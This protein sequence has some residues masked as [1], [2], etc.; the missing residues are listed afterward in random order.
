[1]MNLTT[2]ATLASLGLPEP[3]AKYADTMDPIWDLI[4]W[5]TTFFF[6]IIVGTLILFMIKYHRRKGRVLE[7]APTHHT[8]L[9]IAWTIIPLIIVIALFFIGAQGFNESNAIPSNAYHIAVHGVQWHFDFIYPNGGT[10]NELWV[11]KDQ[12]VV[13]DMT[14]DNVS[15]GLYIPDF[16]A[17]RNIVPGRMVQM[18]FQATEIGDHNIFCTQ[19]CGNGPLRHDHHGPCCRSEGF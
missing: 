3:A 9:E 7:E 19:Y 17:Q 5:I 14:S 4:L 10:S 6:L 11:V 13:L 2:F 15:H 1:M 18:W 8:F 12:P 16:R